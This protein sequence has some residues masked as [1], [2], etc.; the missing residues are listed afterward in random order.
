MLKAGKLR[1]RVRIEHVET[2]QDEL[3]GR[4]TQE[5]SE[6]ATV[7]AAVE[8]LSARGF[9]AMEFIAAAA[10]QSKI[11]A[12]ITIRYRE[13]IDES[14]R[15]IHLKGDREIMYNIHGLLEDND[16]G[17]EYITIPCSRG[18]SVTGQ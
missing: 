9:I 14:M 18:T 8:P 15:L 4:I 11:S 16:S 13:D 3:T 1:H 5:W 7:W 10:I 17:I 6:L 2:I 12:R